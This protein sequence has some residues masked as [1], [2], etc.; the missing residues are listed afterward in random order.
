MTVALAAARPRLR[1]RSFE[2]PAALAAY[3]RIAPVDVIVADLDSPDLPTA[4]LLQFL[5]PSAPPAG[6]RP[7]VIAL[8]RPLAPGAGNLPEGIAEIIVKPVAP[9]RLVKRVLARLDR[10]ALRIGRLPPPR[11]PAGNVVP[12]FGARR[13]P[14]A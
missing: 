9:A 11:P 10:L 8:S 5:G 12:L 14:Q 13:R 6:G 3:M 7:C 1:V 4:A 2:S